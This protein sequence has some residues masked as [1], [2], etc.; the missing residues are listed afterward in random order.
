MNIDPDGFWEFDNSSHIIPSFTPTIFDYLTAQNIS[1]KYFEHHYTF[2]QFFERH[3]FDA[4]NIATFDDPEFG[5]AN[6][7]RT[8]GLPSVTFI[9]P[10]FIELPPGGNCDGPPADVKDGQILVRKVVEA[11][12]ASPTWAKT[13]LIIVS[14]EHGGFYDHVAPPAATPAFP[15]GPATFGNAYHRFSYH[16]GSWPALS[17]VMTA[18]CA[19]LAAAAL[20]ATPVS[21]KRS[22]PRCNLCILITPRSLRPSPGGS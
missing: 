14:D 10:H 19:V 16:R 22:S 17:S 13:L 3:T 7:A 4:T 18:A 1:W 20:L 15:K 6:T 21:G 11:V 12:V 2:L 9:D 8:G 5:F